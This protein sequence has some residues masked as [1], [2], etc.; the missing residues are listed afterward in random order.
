MEF[1][2]D[3]GGVL[4]VLA[5]VV[6]LLAAASFCV[7]GFLA[8]F[9]SPGAM[10]LRIVYACVGLLALVGAVALMIRCALGSTVPARSERRSRS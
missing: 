8:T 4:P 2:R 7:F 9:E 5:A 3:R 6:V 1:S 10:T